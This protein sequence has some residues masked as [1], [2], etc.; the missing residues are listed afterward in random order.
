MTAPSP[1]REATGGGYSGDS[2][3]WPRDLIGRLIF[4]KPIP[5]SHDVT[6]EYEGKPR[7][8]VR[9]DVLVLDAAGVASGVVGG[10]LEYGGKGD[11]VAPHTDRINTPA[12]FSGMLFSQ[13]NIVRE[14]V[15]ELDDAAAGQS[16][17]LLI[18]IPYL[19]DQG[20]KG[21]PP[22][23]LGKVKT[24]QWGRP[25]PGG[26]ALWQFANDQFVAWSGGSLALATKS[27]LIPPPPHASPDAQK[28]YA[29][30]LQARGQ[31]GTPQ[32][33]PTAYASA[34]P[35]A[36]PAPQYAPGQPPQVTPQPPAPAP[37]NPDD[38]PAPGFTPDTW[39]N[40]DAGTRALIWQGIRA[41]QLQPTH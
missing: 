32:P 40:V 8:T 11:A 38:Q 39:G 18:G 25:R 37:G 31:S 21:N 35:V 41:R 16:S 4:L 17:G 3:P 36:A 13:V 10:P 7:P 12:Y 14:L 24:D 33:G 1:F 2:T 34:Q 26:D 30:R 6:A 15:K 29:E 22:L 27:E 5:G 28:R 9:A 20:R 23:N 19:S